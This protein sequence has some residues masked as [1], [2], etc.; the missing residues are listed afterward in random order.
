MR[1]AL[2]KDVL[3]VGK[4]GD[5]KNVSDGYGRNFLLKK[6]LAEISTLEIEKKIELEKEKQ[7]KYFLKLKEEVEVLK[8]K[9]KKLNLVFEVKIGESG[10]P[11][12]SVTPLKVIGELNKQGIKLKKE[13]ISSKPVKTLGESKIKIIL[14]PGIEVFLNILVRPE[15]DSKNG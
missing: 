10:Q 6:K 2:L 9:I 14:H 11:F 13:Q 3:G 15:N 8:E 5:I 4:R 1:V 12:G 7:N